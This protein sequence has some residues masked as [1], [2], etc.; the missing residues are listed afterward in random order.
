MVPHKDSDEC[1]L[2]IMSTKDGDTILFYHEG[3]VNVGDVDSKAA[4]LE[5][6]IGT[7]PT[8]EEIEKKLLGKVTCQPQEARLQA[9]SKL[10]SNS[11]LT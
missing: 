2:A 9:S 10:C 6:P 1:Y 7:F 8:L 3:G 5:V 11:M 4:R